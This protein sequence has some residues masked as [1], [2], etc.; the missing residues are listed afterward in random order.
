M[1]GFAALGLVTPDYV[2]P[3]QFL[4]T[5]GG[6]VNYAGVDQVPYAPL[7][8]DGVMAINRSGAV[9]PN[10]ATN[11][12]GRS[13]TATPS[14]VSVVEYYNAS[15]DHYFISALQPDIDALDSGRISGW[16]RTGQTFKVFPSQTSGGAGVNPV[17]RFYIP[18]QHGNSHFSASPV[19]C[20]AI[21]QKTATDPNYSGHVY[22]SPNVFFVALP[23]TTT[24]TC[25]TA[26]TPIYRLWNQRADF[27]SPLYR[28]SRDQSPDDCHGLSRRGLRARGGDHVRHGVT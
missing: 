22:E 16:S 7:P 18:P 13:A 14:P 8:T 3:N 5:D 25:P 17:C 15:L 1:Q 27:Q 26:T 11:F 19:E 6:T 9:V 12:A 21:V 23:D 20:A 10:V 2:I 24:G 4:A 28:R